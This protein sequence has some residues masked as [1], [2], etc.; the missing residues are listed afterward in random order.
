[1]NAIIN[2]KPI[3][4][5]VA[6]TDDEWDK[7]DP[8]LQSELETQYVLSIPGMKEKL[9][10]YSEKGKKLVFKGNSWEQYT[11]LNDKSQNKFHDIVNEML[12]SDNPSQGN[13]KYSLSEKDCLICSFDNKSL[14]IHSIQT[15][16]V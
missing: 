7:L 1:M 16:K 11:F 14:C 13:G 15:Q 5:A 9:T 12:R 10:R 2:E 6:Y 3:N 4:P 8:D